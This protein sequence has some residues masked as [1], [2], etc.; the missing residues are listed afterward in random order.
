MKYLI[1]LDNL[2]P[3]RFRLLIDFFV[4]HTIPFEV[5]E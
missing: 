2:D 3:T 4:V 5:I 1:D